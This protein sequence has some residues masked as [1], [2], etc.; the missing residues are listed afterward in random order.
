M[1]G[2]HQESHVKSHYHLFFRLS[3]RQE[4]SHEITVSVMFFLN[5]KTISIIIWL[6]YIYYFPNALQC[7][8]STSVPSSLILRFIFIIK[9]L[10]NLNEAHFNNNYKKK[11]NAGN[12]LGNKGREIGYTETYE[13]FFQGLANSHGPWTWALPCHICSCDMEACSRGP[14]FCKSMWMYWG[15]MSIWHLSVS[16]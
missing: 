14:S 13:D 15:I 7:I 5:I 9:L 1:L 3:N 4:I 6:T 2:K 12:V 11:N 16:L 8:F 10:I